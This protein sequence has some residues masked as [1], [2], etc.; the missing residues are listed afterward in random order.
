MIHP[1][2]E[3]V[4]I[5]SEVGRGVRATTRIPTGTLV[6]VRDRFDHVLSQEQVDELDSAHRRLVETWG[7]RDHTGSWVLCSDAGRFVNHS[8]SPAMRG[9]GPD[10]MIAVRP[11][12]IGEE[13][14]CDYA[15]CNTELVCKCGMPTCRGTV[16][17]RDLLEHAEAW[18]A[19]VRDAMTHAAEI[20]QPLLSFAVDW[21]RFKKWSAGAPIPSLTGV[22]FDADADPE[23]EPVKGRRAIV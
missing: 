10:M 21:R 20:P 1:D 7:Y 18:D 14:T 15:E 16:R 13:L 22:Y 3:L 6:W 23:S 17:G 19:E 11:I 5:N 12:E 4:S 2:T 9:L 8:C